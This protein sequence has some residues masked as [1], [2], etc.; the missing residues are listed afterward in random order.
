[1]ES[2]A[3]INELSASLKTDISSVS[4]W[5]NDNKMSLNCKKTKIMKIS[6][7]RKFSY[8][9]EI[10]IDVNDH[11]IKKIAHTILLGVTLDQHL[12]WDK[13]VNNIY[14]II[15]SR[16]YLLKRI[17]SYLDLQCRIQFF[18]ALVYPYLLYCNTLWG[19]A[20]NKL[21]T[22]LLKLQKR[23]ARLFSSSSITLFIHADLVNRS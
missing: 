17:G 14:N 19:N 2:G 18:Y 7:Q 4:D 10:T 5:T 1:M 22:Y 15:N 3:D 11:I 9:S 16:L 20:D 13:Q 6:S 21:I 8:L 23:A 12:K